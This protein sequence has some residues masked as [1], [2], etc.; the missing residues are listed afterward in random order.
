VEGETL[1]DK[2]DREAQ[3]GI[4]EA[5]RITCEVADA[6]DYAHRHGVIHRDIKPENILLHDGRPMVADFGIALAVSAAAGGR[7]TETGLSLGTPHYMS[8]E[9]ATAQ[10]DLTG[11]SDIYSLGAVLHEMLAGDPPHTGST[12]QQIIM[13][14]VTEEAEPVT[15][16][17]QTVPPHVAA[18]VATALQKLAA[19]RFETA[20]K[21]AEALHDPHYAV[22]AGRGAGTQVTVT[23]GGRLPRSAWAV[24]PA[25]LV[26]GALIGWLAR[27]VPHVATSVT[28]F[29][30]PVPQGHVIQNFAPNLAVAPDGRAVA[31]IAGDS[32]YVRRLN[33]PDAQSL[34]AVGDAFS[35][36]FSED[37]DWVYLLVPGLGLGGVSVDGGPVVD[38]QRRPIDQ[39]LVA[40]EFGGPSRIRHAGDTA[41]VTLTTA[42]PDGSE[43]VHARPQLLDGG[44]LVLYTRLGP[45]M[46]WS[47]ASVV[48]EEIATGE[49]TTIVEGGTYGRYV[50]TG[51]VVYITEDG[52]LEAVPVDLNR[53]QPTGPPIT[54]QT[55]VRT[56]YWGGAG[57]FAI[58]DAGTLVFV[59]GSSW[60]LHRLTWLDRAGTVVEHVGAPVTVE[61]IRLSPDERYGVS[62]V[63][64]PKA[65]IARFDLRTGEQRRL[66]FDDATEDNPV[67]S[68]DGREV[69]Y[70]KVVAGNDHRVT[71]APLDGQGDMRDIASFPS[72]VI[73]RAWS[74]DGQVIV[75]IGGATLLT[76][77]VDGS[78]VDTVTTD[79][80]E[81]AGFSPDGR[82]L[83]Y[84]S[85]ETGR[86]EIYVVSYPSRATKY[87]IST[88]G[89]RMPTWSAR[90]GELF[91]LNADTMMVSRVS[92]SGGFDWDAPRALFAE[93]DL[94][95]LMHGYGV[96]ADGRRFLVP[97][98]NPDAAVTEIN[99]VLNWFEELAGR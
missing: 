45:G 41:W 42:A 89:G 37:G 40:G 80:V 27:P 4:D 83:A 81:S 94:A 76:M 11:R 87:Q 21:F 36:L 50:P 55:G 57:S 30:I 39:T 65:D 34:G 13:K 52:S 92:T 20:A 10:K 22:A 82:W 2:L 62:Y 29:T 49:R 8:P 78:G 25:L 99:V 12:V 69:V 33:R 61:G 93:P 70:R 6:L 74:P 59:R 5:V 19:D 88:R 71:I 72:A 32:L 91:F 60:A 7:M 3:L 43:G 48:L 66:T 15:N 75:G 84:D 67:W 79:A 85:R 23:G 26:V 9:Q 18:A 35:P 53:R 16:A 63:A 46:M 77:H 38:F 58:S 56:A 95:D 17:R 24:V 86:S 68:P 54:V 47:G 64:S 1:R 97:T 44:R 31:Y 28:R 14:I 96:T 90:S 98:R 73:P 51:H